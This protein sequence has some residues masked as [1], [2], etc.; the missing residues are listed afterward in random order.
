MLAI[1]NS[2]MFQSL[3]ADL[4]T[5]KQQEGIESSKKALSTHPG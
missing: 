2:S 1:P 5:Q 3:I 4:L